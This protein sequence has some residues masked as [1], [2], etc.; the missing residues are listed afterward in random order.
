MLSHGPVLGGA[1]GG[2]Q[3]RGAGPSYAP[4]VPHR[5]SPVV[6]H[7]LTATLECFDGILFLAVILEAQKTHR[8]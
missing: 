2:M 7:D 1:T 4:S 5:P 6:V 8:E 3:L